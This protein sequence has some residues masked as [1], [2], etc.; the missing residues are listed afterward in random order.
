MTAF[1]TTVEHWH[2]AIR[3]HVV[4]ALLTG[5]I[6]AAS[7][8]HIVLWALQKDVVVDPRMEAACMF[9]RKNGELLVAIVLF[10]KLHC[11]VMK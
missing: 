5:A 6:L 8:Y 9:P 3:R 4:V 11:W 7:T 2:A 10:D 1:A